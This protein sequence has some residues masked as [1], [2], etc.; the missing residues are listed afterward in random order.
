MSAFLKGFGTEPV[1]LLSAG[2]IHSTVNRCQC[3]NRRMISGMI[4]SAIFADSFLSWV[5]GK[6]NVNPFCFRL[7]SIN[8]GAAGWFIVLKEKK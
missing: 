5:E 2:T 6:Q 3:G 1:S 7:G 4:V 8:N